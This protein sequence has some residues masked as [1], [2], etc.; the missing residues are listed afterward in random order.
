M[1]RATNPATSDRRTSLPS[2][3]CPN[4]AV[5]QA[6]DR[7]QRSVVQVGAT[8][9]EEPL[10]AGDR[11][12]HVEVQ[13]QEGVRLG[14][15]EVGAEPGPVEQVPRPPLAHGEQEDDR[16]DD[17]HPPRPARSRLGESAAGGAAAPHQRARA[18]ARRRT[19]RRTSSAKPRTS[20]RSSP[21]TARQRT[22]GRRPPPSASNGRPVWLARS[23]SSPARSARRR[24]ERR[25][26]KRTW[27]ASR[28]PRWS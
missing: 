26:K 18:P 9:D 20:V 14:V 6:G 7:Q 12:R 25:V 17:R 1:S 2:A 8:A 11:R 10:R 23:G 5:R 16:G 4:S 27:V 28:M 13:A 24:N 21:A 15:V 3:Q 19:G 22:H